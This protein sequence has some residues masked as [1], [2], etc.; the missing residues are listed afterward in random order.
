MIPLSHSQRAALLRLA[1]GR[2]SMK[3]IGF[4][5]TRA[6]VRR[7]LVFTRGRWVYIRRLGLSHVAAKADAERAAP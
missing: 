4:A 3:D 5:I 6:L 7:G 2:R 1:D